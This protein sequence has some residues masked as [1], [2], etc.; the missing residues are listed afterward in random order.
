VLIV[1]AEE[2]SVYVRAIEVRAIEVGA[3]DDVAVDVRA[4]KVGAVEQS[5]SD[6]VNAVEVGSVVDGCRLSVV[7]DRCC[8]IMLRSLLFTGGRAVEVGAVVDGC[9]L[10]IVDCCCQGR[11][12]LCLSI[13]V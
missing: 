3:F 5:R 13:E 8:C 7:D 6:A 1:A 9:L 11:I 10:L 4:I 2:R 12:G